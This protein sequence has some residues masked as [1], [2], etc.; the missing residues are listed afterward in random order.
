[1]QTLLKTSILSSLCPFF[2]M[3]HTGLNPVRSTEPNVG[4]TTISCGGGKA[5]PVSTA[6]AEI[7]AL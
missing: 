5:L 3:S 6:C 4:V 7:E 2:S 1:M